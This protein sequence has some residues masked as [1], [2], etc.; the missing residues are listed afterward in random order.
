MVSSSEEVGGDAGS[1]GVSLVEGWWEVPAAPV[2]WRERR[3]G[4]VMWIYIDIS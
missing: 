4:V 1:G 3:F 2:G